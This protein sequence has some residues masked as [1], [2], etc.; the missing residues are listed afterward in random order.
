MRDCEHCGKP[1]AEERLEALPGTTTCV[2]CSTEERVVGY[3]SYAHKTAPALIVVNP[4]D[5][6]ALRL[7]QRANRRSR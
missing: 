3:L 6:E 7:A 1:I 2:N 5:K 4:K